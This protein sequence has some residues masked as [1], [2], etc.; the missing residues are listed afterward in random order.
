MSIDVSDYDKLPPL[1]PVGL[2]QFYCAELDITVA[3]ERVGRTKWQSQASTTGGTVLAAWRPARLRR[4]DAVTQERAAQTVL[5]KAVQAI[6][7]SIGAAALMLHPYRLY[8]HSRGK[9]GYTR[10]EIRI[11]CHDTHVGEAEAVDCPACTADLW[12]VVSVMAFLPPG[13]R[14]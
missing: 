8:T 14:A 13:E 6:T 10:C 5:A 12:R 2:G 3:T 11:V 9:N 7:A 4:S 1:T